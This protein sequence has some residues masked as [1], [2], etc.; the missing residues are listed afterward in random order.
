MPPAHNVYEVQ[1]LGNKGALARNPRRRCGVRAV[2]V[3]YAGGIVAYACA[4]ACGSRWKRCALVESCPS[5]YRRAWMRG[6]PRVKWP[7][8][9]RGGDCNPSPPASQPPRG[10]EEPAVRFDRELEGRR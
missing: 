10:A 9:A 5:A 6:M 4:C 8:G 2:R 1:E 7:A 3:V